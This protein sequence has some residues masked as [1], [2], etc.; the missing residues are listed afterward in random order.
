[1]EGNRRD[2][3]STA[4]N[5]GIL[6]T[7]VLLAWQIQPANS[8]TAGQM[9]HESL[10]GVRDMYLAQ[11]GEDPAD[12][13]AK[14]M[15]APEALTLAD[16]ARLDA[17]AKAFV[18]QVVRTNLLQQRGFD[19]QGSPAGRPAGRPGGHLRLLDPA[20]TLGPGM[21]VW[22]PRLGRALRPADGDRR[23][24]DHGDLCAGLPE[25]QEFCGAEQVVHAQYARMRARLQQAP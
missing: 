20:G 11:A 17:Y 4:G 6:L 12:A 7:L 14:A 13:I 21:V 25:R 18:H 9:T 19:V 5:T 24:R 8:L 2:W 16:H 3:L 15:E 10:L 22:Q 23:R 1:M